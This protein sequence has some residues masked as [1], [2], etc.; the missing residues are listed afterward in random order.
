MLPSA[1]RA[2][3]DQLL[4]WYSVHDTEMAVTVTNDMSVLDQPAHHAYQQTGLTN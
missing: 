4:S 3:Y 1:R 2:D